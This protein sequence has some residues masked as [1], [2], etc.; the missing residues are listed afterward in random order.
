MPLEK[1]IVTKIKQA[2]EAAGGKVYKIHGGPYGVAGA[3]DLIGGL[4]PM[5]FVLEVK[6]PGKRATKLQQRELDEWEEQGWVSAVVCS[7]D[8]AM[9]ALKFGAEAFWAEMRSIVNE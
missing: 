2:I 8:E 5:P 3:P 7:A 4:G 9:D 6:R 1:T